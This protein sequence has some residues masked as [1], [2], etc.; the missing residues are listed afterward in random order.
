MSVL[1]YPRQFFSSAHDEQ[2]QKS[3][4]ELDSHA[5]TTCVGANCWNIAYID[6]VCSVTPSHP[7]YKALQ[8]VPIIQAGMANEDYET[9]NTCV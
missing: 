8:N 9:G 4:I 7:K 6:R 1:L 3:L 5:D 2:Y